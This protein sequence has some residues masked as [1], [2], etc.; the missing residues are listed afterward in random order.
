MSTLIV[1]L[2]VFLII[3]VYLSNR[4]TK[5]LQSDFY[6]FCEITSAFYNGYPIVLPKDCDEVI[7]VAKRERRYVN[8]FDQPGIVF[9]S[10]E[11][12]SPW[13]DIFSR[14]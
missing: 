8:P 9:E 7:I 12:A 4:R 13:P 1:C 6:D 5:I 3:Y 11:G 10:R 14:N 2:L